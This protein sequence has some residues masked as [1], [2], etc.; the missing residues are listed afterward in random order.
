MPTFTFTAR[1]TSGKWHKGTETADN[2]SGLAGAL[3]GRGLSLVTAQAAEGEKSDAKPGRGWGILPPMGLDIELGL[4]MIANML[5][6]GLTLMAALKTCADQARRV[7]MAKIWD[8][9]HDQ[10]AAGHAFAEAM[11]RHKARFPR[12]VIKLAEAG[13]ASGSLEL[14]LQQAADQME[15]KRNLLITVISA[16]LY[17]SITTVI[18]IGVAVYLVTSVVPTIAGFLTSQGKKLPAMTLAL[19]ATSDFIR[20]YGVTI[21]IVIVAL[22][23]GLIIA[24]FNKQAARV[25]DGAILRVPIVGKIFRLGSTTMFARGLGMMLEAGVPMIAALETA[26]GLIKN[27]AVVARIEATR[28]SV[29]AGQ[30]VAR[31]LAEGKEFLPMLPRMVAIGEETGTLGPVLEKVAVFHEKQLE[32]YIKRMTLLIEPVMTVIVGG[33]VGFVYLAFF[34][35]IYSIAGSGGGGG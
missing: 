6:G 1:D 35:A 28:K 31:P 19:L 29:L 34:M 17:P 26:A 12:L 22:V 24:H 23:A 5:D 10:V 25:I 4:L 14:V 18:A 13:E 11:K 16:L 33:M 3:R 15:R 2:S 7:R 9:I 8:D 32:A 21:F 20:V 30:G 27:K